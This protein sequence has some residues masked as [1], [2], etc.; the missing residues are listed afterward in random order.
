M[1]LTNL[2]RDGPSLVRP[3]LAG[4]RNSTHTISSTVLNLKDE[5][6]RRHLLSPHADQPKRTDK[7]TFGDWKIESSKKSDRSALSDLKTT[8]EF[9]THELRLRESV[10]ST[11]NR[12]S[13]R[14]L[15]DLTDELNRIRSHTRAQIAERPLSSGIGGRLSQ[16]DTPLQGIR[17]GADDRFDKLFD[18]SPDHANAKH[19]SYKDELRRK[20]FADIISLGRIYELQDVLT[21]VSDKEFNEL[22]AR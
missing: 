14:G 8:T 6:S 11:E 15:G 9:R 1:A 21:D 7:I 17:T 13:A 18:I 4:I 5:L 20:N 22:P 19:H 12:K 2:Y 10:S 3:N 16:H